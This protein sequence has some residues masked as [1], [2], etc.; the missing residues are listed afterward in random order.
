MPDFSGLPPVN[1]GMIY[2]D[3]SIYY[4]C[5]WKIF[6]KNQFRKR[7]SAIARQ[8]GNFGNNIQPKIM[9]R[10]R[11]ENRFRARLPIRINSIVHLRFINLKP[12]TVRCLTWINVYY[13]MYLV[14]CHTPHNRYQ[15][16]YFYYPHRAVNDVV[17]CVDFSSVFFSFLSFVP[18]IQFF[19]LRVLELY[20]LSDWR[21]EVHVN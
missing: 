7:V 1:I 8:G 21:L 4:I 10:R 15:T 20:G 14:P 17:V 3:G 12:E 2:D 5:D 13:T 18:S 19:F 6:V 9:Q 11:S 16:I